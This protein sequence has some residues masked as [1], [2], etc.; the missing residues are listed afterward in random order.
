VTHQKIVS[1]ICKA[2]ARLC[3]KDGLRDKKHFIE[4]YLK[5]LLETGQL[6]MTVPDKPN[7][8]NQKYV[9]GQKNG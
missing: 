8:K 7:S 5:P 6:K 3:G 9:R 4:K 2:F 1:C